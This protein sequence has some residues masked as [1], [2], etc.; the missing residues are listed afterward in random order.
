MTALGLRIVA[1]NGADS[2][3]SPENLRPATAVPT[4]AGA[5]VPATL[6]PASRSDDDWA[7]RAVCANQDPDVL[8]VT[9]AAQ[10]EAARLCHGC[11]VKL[12]CL[13]DAL[14]NRVEFGVWGG[15]TERQRRALLKRCPEVTSWRTVLEDA[16]T[17]AT[18]PV[19]G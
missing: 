16:R 2:P 7:S 15:L 17:E 6:A 8:F 10:R 18:R 1:D 14:D 19:A 11:P 13:A 3:E 4:H 9:G 5:T 12:E